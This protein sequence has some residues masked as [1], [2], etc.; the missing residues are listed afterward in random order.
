[1]KYFTF[2][3]FRSALKCLK[4]QHSKTKPNMADIIPNFDGKFK[5]SVTCGQFITSI[6]EYAM[7]EQLSEDNMKALCLTKLSG[8]A[9]DVFHSH[10]AKS[11]PDLKSILMDR[12][13]VKLSIKEK[14]ELRKN[15][16]QEVAEEIDEFY[17]RCLQAQY[18]VSD[19][20]R[21]V[22][23][24][25]EVLLSFLLGLVPNIQEMVLTA[26]CNSA[27]EFVSEAKKHFVVPKSEY[28][29]TEVKMEPFEDIDNYEYE[30]ND[31]DF[32]PGEVD[33]GYEAFYDNYDPEYEDKPL[34]TKVK[35]KPGRPKKGEEPIKRSVKCLL[36]KCDKMFKT[37]KGRDRHI[38][39]HHK[40]DKR[41]C[42]ICQEE[43]LDEDGL[44][45]HLVQKHC[46]KNDK[47]QY[48]CYLCHAYHR[49]KIR[50]V[51]R[52]I[53][54]VHWGSK[55][56]YFNCPTCGKEFEKKDELERHVLSNHSEK[57]F[58]CDKC[59]SSFGSRIGLVNHIKCK[60]EEQK[61]VQCDKCE[62]TF[63]NE[64]RLRVHYRLQHTM[65]KTFVCDF[66]GKSFK[67]K[68]AMEEHRL[69]IHTSWE[70]KEKLKMPCD[71]PDCDYKGIT[72][73]A[74][75]KHIDRVHLKIRNHICPHC[76][77]AFAAIGPMKEH[78]NGTHLGL[79]PIKCPMC[80][81]CTAYTTIANE[82]KRIVHGNQ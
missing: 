29:V 41:H 1:M 16:K 73:A 52:H 25:R 3:L 47:G 39:E 26:D 2:Y 56:V 6:E 66:C 60:H 55:D 51:R 70:E 5:G 33:P 27:D 11:W 44:A 20:V 35:R 62:R 10:M 19:D 32:E 43:C 30:A 36:A 37:S 8:V 22:A 48:V 14:V 65:T 59:P 76:S 12:F 28:L 57:T 50:D 72:K 58:H 63:S 40:D 74:L 21:D 68:A 53:Q 18:L 75:K 7:A 49:A 80:D 54:A 45:R 82:H 23:F 64:L 24:E 69:K 78:I 77:K 79:K 17:H 67:A 9:M 42:D 81:F 61:E 38:V 46:S 13:S 71:Y 34:A 4:N 31:S 15:L